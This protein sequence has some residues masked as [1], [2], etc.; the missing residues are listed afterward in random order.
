MQTRNQRAE[1]PKPTNTSRRH[2]AISM[3]EVVDIDVLGSMQDDD[4]ILRLR[5]LEE[6]RSRA[7]ADGRYDTYP[8]EVEAAYVRREQQIRR[9]R[10]DAHSEW[11]WR[12]KDEFERLEASLP[13]GDFDNTAFVY[14]AMGARTR[15]N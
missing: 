15:W 9:A 5:A 8:W 13:N 3:P 11:S 2:G 1:A 10:R 7:L 14:A 4:L 12:L 6:D